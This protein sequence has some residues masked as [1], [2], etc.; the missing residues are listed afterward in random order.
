MIFIIIFKK[1]KNNIEVT[2][3]KPEKTIDEKTEM[4]QKNKSLNINKTLKKGVPSLSLNF[5]NSFSSNKE[6]AK[7]NI[8]NLKRKIIKPKINIKLNTFEKFIEEK[9]E[10]IPKTKTININKTLNNNNNNIE[11]KNNINI[12]PPKLKLNQKLSS[13]EITLKGTKKINLDSIPNK[14]YLFNSPTIYMNFPRKYSVY[15]EKFLESLHPP[16]RNKKFSNIISPRI[17]L[18]TNN[19]QEMIRHYDKK[20]VEQRKRNLPWTKSDN[21]L[22][23]KNMEKAE[24]S[25]E[26]ISGKR[27]SKIYYKKL[28]NDYIKLDDD[29]D[30]ISYNKFINLVMK[31]I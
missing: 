8:Y 16:Y 21:V 1:Y 2:L 22:I 9:K 15:S 29:Y 14:K 26:M 27:K 10:L 17:S 4:I 12:T 13:F 5:S 11:Q 20:S 18:M 25:P 7:R 19:L 31:D 3:V 28:G 6:K 24:T 30:M 23:N